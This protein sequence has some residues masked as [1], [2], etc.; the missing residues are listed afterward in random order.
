M[1]GN[2]HRQVT[3]KK[4]IRG[5]LPSDPSPDSSGSPLLGVGNGDAA[6]TADSGTQMGRV[7]NIGSTK[8]LGIKN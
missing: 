8:K 6:A 7:G 1:Q 3:Y 4:F 2:G 5:N